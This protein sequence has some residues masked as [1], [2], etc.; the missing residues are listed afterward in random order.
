[1]LISCGDKNAGCPADADILE[2]IYFE[3]G[4]TG[5]VTYSGEAYA[6]DNH[7]CTFLV[8]YF[9][10]GWDDIY[11]LTDSGIYVQTDE[12]DLFPITNTFFDDMESYTDL[13][14]MMATSVEDT[15]KNWNSF[16]LQSPLAPT[17]EEYVDLRT[18]ILTGGC[19]FLDNRVDIV[20][21]PVN[22]ANKVM[23]C[24]AVA[25]SAD[26]VTSKSSIDRTFNYFNQGMDLYFEMRC[27]IASGMPYSLV[28]FENDGFDQSPGPRVVIMDNSLVIE[29]KFGDKKMYYSDLDID[30]PS[31]AWF[32]VKVHFRFSNQ[33]DGIIELWQDGNL[34]ISTNGINLPLATSVQ[35][36]L[37]VGVS[38]TDIGAVLLVDDVRLSPTAF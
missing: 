10:E 28:D 7:G 3:S 15:D 38:A 24:T 22:A 23:Q 11:V 1:M 21:D 18:C 36:S 17:I 32:T 34:L 33:S 2:T 12:G 35:N 6:Q 14:S 30:I 26:M 13:V 20:T 4:E 25:P 8:Q 9:T 31:D 5:I 37:E 19:D 27:Y 16:T 29:N